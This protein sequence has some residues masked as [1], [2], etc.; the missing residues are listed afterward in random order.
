MKKRRQK[1]PLIL[2]TLLLTA[3]GIAARIAG[4]FY[5]IFLSHK[6][7]T[8]A[9]GLY[10][11]VYP[12][13]GICFSLCCG[14]IQTAISRFVA[15]EHGKKGEGNSRRYLACGLILALSLSFAAAAIMYQYAPFLALH[16]LSEPRCE[17][18][19]RILSFSVPMS[20]VH[21]CIC[22]YYYGRS[23]AQVPAAAQLIEQC[24][25]IM[26]V[27]AVVY[28]AESSGKT[29][30]AAYAVVGHLAGEAGALLSSLLA[31]SFHA[32]KLARE[33]GFVQER[34]S[35][36]SSYGLLF[37]NLVLMV[38]PLTA[39]RLVISLLQS[40][41]AIMIPG[42]LRSFGLSSGDALS[43][44]GVLTGMSLP[45]I[46]F[47]TAITNSLSV[48]LLPHIAEAQSM[49]AYESINY[50]SAVSI[51]YS[52]YIGILFAG[53]FLYFGPSVGPI[54][55][56]NETAGSFLSVL[57]W[58]CP[59]LYVSGTLN[60][61]ING[62]GYAKTTFF[63][64]AIGL[65]IRLCFVMFLIP[66]LGIRAYLYGLLCSELTIT[67]FH[68][69]FLRKKIELPFSPFYELIRPTLAVFLSIGIT[70]AHASLPIH[71]GMPALLDLLI[72]GILF[73]VCF[74]FFLYV[75]RHKHS[76]SRI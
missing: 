25:R 5:R 20:A 30:T 42:R 12:I 27:I 49:K 63:H 64:T 50:S 34:G 65:T 70:M 47:P 22:G 60:S 21:A 71:E 74:L 14:S 61:I 36:P 2:G 56:H 26:T 1:N 33:K 68:L 66:R 10:Q 28:M 24:V 40:A 62:L 6:I 3:S 18:L 57:A 52:L 13:Y 44:Y 53:I 59:F 16:V 38:L 48:M 54:I 7:S 8:E 75:T 15:A 11:L 46:L 9:M 4:F 31:F 19:L 67:L 73:V 69:S 43:L 55:F 41:E 29:I 72:S 35:E 39:N 17:N 32:S 76:A 23:K 45:F 58:L 51:R 37:R